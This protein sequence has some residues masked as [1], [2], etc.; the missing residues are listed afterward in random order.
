MS[1]PSW[2]RY[3]EAITN[4]LP[5]SHGE[6]LRYRCGLSLLRDNA[7]K[8]LL[9]ASDIAIPLLTEVQRMGTVYTYSAPSALMKPIWTAALQMYASARRLHEAVE[10]CGEG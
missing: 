10:K 8:S 6:D 3:R 2:H 7:S 4:I 1:E 5:G 9:T